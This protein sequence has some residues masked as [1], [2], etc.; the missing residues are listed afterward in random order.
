M[1]FWIRWTDYHGAIF[2]HF[3]V[4][5]RDLHYYGYESFKAAAETGYTWGIMI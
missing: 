1:G 2:G 3:V 4:S 5:S